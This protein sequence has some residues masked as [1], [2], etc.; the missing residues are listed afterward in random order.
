MKMTFTIPH[1]KVCDSNVTWS[2]LILVRR[3]CSSGAM[4]FA[5]LVRH[6]LA[7]LQHQL[8]TVKREKE[9]KSGSGLAVLYR[10]LGWSR[11]ECDIPPRRM[12]V[13]GDVND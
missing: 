9:V 3:V 8:V 7:Y 10:E 12:M 2:A 5:I 1:R 6:V 11:I 13:A 4:C